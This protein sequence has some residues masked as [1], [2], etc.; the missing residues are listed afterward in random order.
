MPAENPSEATPTPAPVE[1]EMDSIEKAVLE[2]M[3]SEDYKQGE[4]LIY[5]CKGHYFACV[6]DLSFELCRERRDDAILNKR[7]ILPC[8]PLKKYKTQNECFK[9]QYQ[10]IHNPKD[11]LFCIHFKNKPKK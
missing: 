4:H 2:P 8:A 7:D 3:I 11:K 1:R 9:N 6:N 10:Q 5:D